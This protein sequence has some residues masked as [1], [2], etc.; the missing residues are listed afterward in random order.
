MRITLVRHGESEANIG[1]WDYTAAGDHKVHLTA[2]GREQAQAAGRKLCARLARTDRGSPLVYCSPYTRTRQ[3]LQ[4]LYAGSGLNIEET[5]IYEDA[6]LREIEH[7][8]GNVEEQQPL[9]KVHGWFYYR[10]A[11]GESPADCFDRICTFLES[12]MR[13]VS[14]K[15]PEQVIIVTHGLAIR[16]FVMRFLHLTVDQFE[17]LDNPDNCGIITL[18]LK[19]NLTNPVFTSGRWGVE[20]VRL[21]AEVSTPVRGEP[22]P[23]SN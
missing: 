18:D 2:K 11:G 7:G 15:D 4:E 3:T 19:E 6:R 16:C 20:G 5:R 14:R 17:S 13:Q 8:Y 10:Y 9:R 1:N 22:C 12:M 21:R 23:A